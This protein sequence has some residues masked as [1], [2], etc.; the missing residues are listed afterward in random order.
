MQGGAEPEQIELT[1]VQEGIRLVQ[2]YFWPHA[3]AALRQI[4]LTERHANARKVLKWI[5]ATGKTQVS[6]EDIRRDALGQALDADRTDELIAKS[7]V[8]TGWLSPVPTKKGKRGKPATLWAVNPALNSTAQNA[9][10]G[11]AH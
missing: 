1:F 5:R 8:R 9:E 2:D 11:F 10:N 7:L 4:G 6:R 3:R